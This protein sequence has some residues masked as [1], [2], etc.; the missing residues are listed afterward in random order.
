MAT[1]E[2]IA[3]LQA[4]LTMLELELGVQTSRINDLEGGEEFSWRTE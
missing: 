1:M 2:D 4:K 3:K